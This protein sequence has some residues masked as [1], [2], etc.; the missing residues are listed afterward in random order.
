M[1]GKLG[2]TNLRFALK[3][4]EKLKEESNKNKD[5]LKDN[6]LNHSSNNEN[7]L[8]KLSLLSA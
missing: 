8:D 3:K 2:L 1:L 7:K 5:N 4:R 6:L